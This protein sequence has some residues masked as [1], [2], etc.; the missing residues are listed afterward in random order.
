[1]K[2]QVLEVG[3][4]ACCLLCVMKVNVERDE[5]T[6]VNYRC[7]KG[8]LCKDRHGGKGRRYESTGALREKGKVQVWGCSV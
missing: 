6:G 3:G 7:C 1:M 8:V 4:C 2:V 5:C